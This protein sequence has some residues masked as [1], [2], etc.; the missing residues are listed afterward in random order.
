MRSPRPAKRESPPPEPSS[1]PAQGSRHPADRDWAPSRRFNL[2]A[3]SGATD[4]GSSAEGTNPAPPG[5]SFARVSPDTTSPRAPTTSREAVTSP[6]GHCEPSRPC[7]VV[8]RVTIE[9]LD[10]MPKP[11]TDALDFLEFAQDSLSPKSA[12][13]M[14]E[15]ARAQLRIL[16]K[17]KFAV[18]CKEL[19]DHI[20]S[21][22]PAEK[23]DQP[24]ESRAI[25]G[26]WVQGD[27]T[28]N[29]E[30]AQA[31]KTR[32]KVKGD[33]AN[34]IWVYERAPESS[35]LDLEDTSVARKVDMHGFEL[36][37]VDFKRAMA[38]WTD[39]PEWITRLL[40][41]L[42]ILYAKKGFVAMSDIMRM[43]VLYYKGGLYLD[44]KIKLASPEAEF[45]NEPKVHT[46]ILQCIQ[47]DRLENSALLAE[48]GCMMIETILRKALDK[49]PPIE[50]LK[51]MPVNYEGGMYSKAHKTL[52]ENYGPWAVIDQMTGSIESI[53]QVNPSLELEN[54]RGVN[55][56]AI[57]DDVDF[58]F[59]ASSK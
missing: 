30:F 59:G 14:I 58:D 51:E 41:I 15:G 50:R 49:M 10:E 4:P 24:L 35:D 47:L 53:G 56:W 19:I 42:E 3:A 52:H 11:V 1:E 29:E 48:R 8:Q 57:T 46:D 5:H 40:E 32:E 44:L 18:H 31:L 17:S 43:I 34:L 37:E 45:F 36:V 12:P 28:S 22:L 25:H 21:K 23:I 16:Q 6:A 13:F 54:P 55:S 9:R 38:A 2:S 33:W 26:I 7:I 39:R 27:Y 20:E